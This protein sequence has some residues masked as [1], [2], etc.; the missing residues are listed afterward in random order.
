MN[1][2]RRLDL[3]VHQNFHIWVSF[4]TILRAILTLLSLF[5][6]QAFAIQ[7][8]VV[9]IGIG[10]TLHG[11]VVEQVFAAA[12]DARNT[13]DVEA[14][15]CQA[16]TCRLAVVGNANLRGERSAVGHVKGQAVHGSAHVGDRQLSAEVADR[17]SARLCVQSC[18]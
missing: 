4:Q 17:L 13:R 1:D 3:V 8:V 15:A 12:R 14:V 9:L 18:R 5:Q 6:Y 10:H 11:L 7:E 2:I 16:V